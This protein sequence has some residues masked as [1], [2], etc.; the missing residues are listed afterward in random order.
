MTIAC[1]RS[2][3]NRLNDA[4]LL[5]RLDVLARKERETTLEVLHHLGE[6][7]R[8]RASR[9]IEGSRRGVRGRGVLRVADRA[10]FRR[11]PAGPG[12]AGP[13]EFGSG[14]IARRTLCQHPRIV[15]IFVQSLP[16]REWIVHKSRWDN[17]FQRR[18][19][20]LGDSARRDEAPDPGGAGKR[21]R[22]NPPR[23]R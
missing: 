23:R 14:G 21:S 17:E 1:E 8:R 11:I 2:Q 12:R 16:E 7:D 19:R 9:G 22:K 18:S 5:Q 15:D 13:G 4:Q 6:A 3:L 10:V 20:A